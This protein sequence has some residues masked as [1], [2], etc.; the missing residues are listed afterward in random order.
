MIIPVLI[1]DVKDIVGGVTPPPGVLQWITSNP[2]GAVPGLIPFLSAI[3]RLL[4]VIA[5]LYTLLN[6]ILAGYSFISAGGD[7]KNI[8]KAWAKIWQSLVG[9]LIIA[10]AYLLAAIFGWLLFKDAGAIL[11]P[12]IIGPQ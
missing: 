6:L 1:A 3:I 8:E 9:L 12:K 5:G 11:N 2:G 7:P 10:A 4:T